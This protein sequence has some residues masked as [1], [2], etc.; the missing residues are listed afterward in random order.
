MK[1]IGTLIELGCLISFAGAVFYG[2][3]MCYFM[4]LRHEKK[5]VDTTNAYDQSVIV[6][7]NR[8]GA[9]LFLAILLSIMRECLE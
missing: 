8:H 7:R 6:C 1:V 5:D 9:L 3:S 4:H 2:V